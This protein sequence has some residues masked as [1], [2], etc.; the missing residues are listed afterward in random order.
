MCTLHHVH[1]FVSLLS[2]WPLSF[3]ELF[4][5]WC[6]SSGTSRCSLSYCKLYSDSFV[7]FSVLA[8]SHCISDTN[9]S[10]GYF[11][12]YVWCQWACLR[13]FCVWTCTCYLTEVQ[14]LRDELGAG[15]HGGLSVWQ[16]S[17]ELLQETD[18]LSVVSLCQLLLSLKQQ[19]FCPA[20]LHTH[21]HTRSYQNRFWDVKQRSGWWESCSFC[22]WSPSAAPRF[23]NNPQRNSYIIQAELVNW[24]SE[25]VVEAAQRL[26]PQ[27][28]HKYTHFLW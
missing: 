9:H 11:S 1:A 23:T 17:V 20:H 16:Q 4:Q 27:Q 19:A 25:D 22:Q 12:Q 10:A 18:R 21:T 24:N 2:H 3:M 5:T 6:Q 7:G 15:K 8:Q 28:L 26:S 13:A 14:F